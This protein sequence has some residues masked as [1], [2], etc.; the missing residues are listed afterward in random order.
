MRPSLTVPP[1]PEPCL[2]LGGKLR[3]AVLVQWQFRDDRHSLASSAF[4][5]LTH[6]STTL[7]LLG[8][9]GSLVQV[10]VFLSWWHLGQRRSRHFSLPIA[11]SLPLLADLC[12]DPGVFHLLPQL[13]QLGRRSAVVC[14]KAPLI[15]AIPLSTFLLQTPWPQKVL[16]HQP[17]VVS[18][19]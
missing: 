14:R 6:T 10:Q 16:L 9:D 3:E 18:G 1:V 11:E 15:S 5:F 8:V 4:R 2:K 12:H 13:G 7:V 17:P 19:G